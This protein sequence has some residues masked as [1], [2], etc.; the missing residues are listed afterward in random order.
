M[1]LHKI[2]TKSDSQTVLSREYIRLD[3]CKKNMVKSRENFFSI[4]YVRP[5]F[6]QTT[7]RTST[8]IKS[9]EE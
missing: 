7:N 6:F 2:E 8:Q 9:A 1:K 3:K 5:K 4:S